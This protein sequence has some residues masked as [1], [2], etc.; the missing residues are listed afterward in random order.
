VTFTVPVTVA[1]TVYQSVADITAVL[2]LVT[3]TVA[4]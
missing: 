4:T 3:V 1:F 2:V